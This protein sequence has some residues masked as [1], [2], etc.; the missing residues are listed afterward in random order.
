MFGAWFGGLL[1]QNRLSSG[2]SVNAT[3]KFTISLG[4]L[5]MLPA[6]LAMANPGNPTIAV[7]IMAV[8]LFGFQ[9]AIG[10]V[11]TL[12]SDFFGGKSVGTLAG[13]AGMAAKLG[14]AGLSTYLIPWLTTG[15]NYT[16]AFVVGAALAVIAMAAVW[17]L[18]GEI[19]PLKPRNAEKA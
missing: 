18:C 14:A 1:A 3:R 8:I 7:L 4:C 2:W 6:L 9:T 17:L 11:Q 5:I 16:P 15:G 19:K 12:P 13:F 10:N